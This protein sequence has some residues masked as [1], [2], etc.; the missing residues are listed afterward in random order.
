MREVEPDWREAPT[1]TIEGNAIVACRARSWT[2][3]IL[4][5]D[6]SPIFRHTR[7]GFL[8][9]WSISRQTRRTFRSKQRT[10]RNI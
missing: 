3:L 2:P 9:I 6:T 4:P 7:R 1:I 10:F 5:R 8:R